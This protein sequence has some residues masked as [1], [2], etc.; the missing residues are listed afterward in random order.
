MR[1]RPNATIVARRDARK[2]ELSRGWPSGEKTLRFLN[3]RP[4]AQTDRRASGDELIRPRFPDC[5]AASV[6][7][8]RETQ[9]RKGTNVAGRDDENPL[10]GH[11]S[12]HR[13]QHT[14]DSSNLTSSG[15]S[16]ANLR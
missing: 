11:S 6:S 7:A 10:A 5:G 14:D 9:A 1:N 8:V 12:A 15:I 4:R 16:S 3:I 2:S 13:R